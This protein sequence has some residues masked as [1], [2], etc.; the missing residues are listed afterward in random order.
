MILH[1]QMFTS[2]ADRALHESER[3][4]EFVAS[5]GAPIQTREGPEYLRISGMDL[6][7]FRKNPVILDG[8]SRGSCDDVIGRATVRKE[9]AR[10]ITAIQF[11][12][13]EKSERIYQKVRGGIL[14][15]V[16]IGFSVDPAH[17][18]KLKDGEVDGTGDDEIRGP[19]VVLNKSA[20]HEISVVPI[21]AD[22]D[23]LRRDFYERAFMKYPE[24]SS[25]DDKTAPTTPEGETRSEAPADEIRGETPPELEGLTLEL[26]ADDIT[27][28]D[29]LDATID[30]ERLQREIADTVARTAERVAR[31]DEIRAICPPSLI[32]FLEGYLL[33]DPEAS[34]DASRRALLDE[35]ALTHKPVGTPDPTPEPTEPAPSPLASGDLLTNLTGR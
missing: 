28:T 29:A 12:T 14:N 34:F 24:T 33:A 15:A 25:T 18:R 27:L 23:A 11:A 16:S 6:T 8:H 35:R 32:E 19:G 5:S 26:P 10:L 3:I 2:D 13:D 31:H 9:G 7:R 17:A 22:E 30:A 4:V 20:L 1:R 21:P